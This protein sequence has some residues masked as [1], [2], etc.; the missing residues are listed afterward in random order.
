[1]VNILHS[2]GSLF[3]SFPF[4][5]ITTS[6]AFVLKSCV[7]T[8]LIIQGWRSSKN[9]RPLVLL[10]LVLLGAMISDLAWILKLIQM[11]FVQDMDYRILKFLIRIA[12]GF[13]IV[14]YQALALFLESL[15]EKKPFFNLRQKIF[16]FFSTIL[17]SSFWFIAFTNINY[18]KTQNHSGLE[19]IL[20]HIQSVYMFPLIAISLII[21]ILKLRSSSI[22][23]ILK[24]QTK[25][26]IQVLIAPGVLSDFIQLYPFG[27]S[28]TFIANNYAVVSISTISLTCAMYYCSRKIMGL[29]FLNF[30]SHVQS[31]YKY[32]FIDKFKGVLEQLSH[33]TSVNELGHITQNFFSTGI[34]IPLRRTML[35]IRK[36]DTY[37]EETTDTIERTTE[38]FLNTHSQEICSFVNDSKILIYDEIAF[39]HFY[40]E[41]EHSQIMLNFL[42]SIHA[43]VFLP[44]YEKQKVIAYIIVERFA[45]S[46]E[47]YSD[48]ERDEMIVYASYL[49]NV[50]NLLQNRNLS[51]LIQQEKELQEELYH[52]HQEINQYKESIRSFIRDAQQKKIGII[53]YKNRRFTFGNQTAQEL[54]HININVQEGHPL[55]R[56]LKTLA[57]QVEQYKAQKTSI[58]FNSNGEKL[59]LSGIPNSERNNV[60]ITISRPDISDLLAKK[61]ELLDD[62]TKWDYLL[63]LETTKSGKLINQLVP[64]TSETLLTFK[65]DLLKTAL[66][67]KATLLEMSEHDLKPTVELLHHISLREMLYTLECKPNMHVDSVGA[68]LFG[69]N[70]I[71]TLGTAQEKPL[72]EQLDEIGTLFIKNIHLLDLKLQES[73][74][75]FIKYGYFKMLKS[76]TKVESNVRIICSSNQPLQ[77]LAQENKF[78]KALFNELKKTSIAMPSLAQLTKEELSALADGYA[79]QAIKTED[80]KNLLELSESE[81]NKL[82]HKP[83]VSLQDLKSH[84]QT[85]LVKKSKKSNLDEQAH[86]DPAYEVTDPELMHAARLG[87][88]ALRDEKTM[89]LLWKKFKNQSKMATFL[90]VNRSSINRRCKEY[91]LE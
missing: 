15:V 89:N 2:L 28:S 58:A 57:K 59:V 27:F 16:I 24:K 26:F 31:P 36:N 11:L 69:I 34:N 72:L 91:N 30:K 12:W 8:I 86:F 33:A 61:I 25:V 66:S 35:Y 88:H 19:F 42:D 77:Q 22:P 39:S 6:T 50:I 38:N 29:R 23:K 71:F 87:K 17:C 5:L 10:S 3:G 67:K 80:F 83:P 85:L 32:T 45:R 14:E 40:E 43:D 68:K 76:D 60:V 37:K 46:H 75:E 62:P 47:L 20:Q 53:F 84:V 64:G 81:K 56:T 44:V 70:P 54:I 1:M 63:Y 82:A 90:G 52:K 74:A 41:T 48:V 21:T 13:T 7:L 79:Q 51:V 78:S 18:V 73:L 49:G 9:H 55:T 65:L 4:L